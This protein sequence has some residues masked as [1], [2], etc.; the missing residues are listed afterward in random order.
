MVEGTD[1]KFCIVKNTRILYVLLM[2]CIAISGEYVELY[3]A[4]LPGDVF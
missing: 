2:D 1:V 4:I 3:N